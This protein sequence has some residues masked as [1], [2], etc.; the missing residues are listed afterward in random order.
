MSQEPHIPAVAYGM[1]VAID[2]REQSMRLGR[3]TS[4]F[5]LFAVLYLGFPRLQAQAQEV[6]TRTHG[7]VGRNQSAARIWENNQ[8]RVA[9]P[10][11]WKVSTARGALI[12]SKQSYTLRIGYS[13]EHASGITGGRFIEAFSVPWQNA[14]DGW[15][16]SMYMSQ[17]PLPA[18]RQLLFMSLVLDTGNETVRE[19]CGIAKDLGGW[20]KGTYRGDRRWFGGYFTTG[21][22][23][24]FFSSECGE[25]LYTLVP[26]AKRAID[27]P[28]ADDL[29]LKEIINEAIDIVTSIKYKGC[30]PVG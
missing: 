7:T 1:K 8:I 16:C 30:P 20:D 26:G 2:L 14:D 22:G 6:A 15:T 5:A 12:L 19:H 3:H 18:N 10:N 4:C 24:W 9:I 28:D 27:L 23:G 25:M 21:S 17:M 13:A 11:D 29:D